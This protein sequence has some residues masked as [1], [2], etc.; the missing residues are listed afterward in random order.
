MY[1]I[2]YAFIRCTQCDLIFENELTFRNHVIDSGHETML[3]GQ[4]Y[5]SNKRIKRSAAKAAQKIIDQINI[6]LVNE[7]D[8]ETQAQGQKSDV[9]SIKKEN[10]EDEWVNTFF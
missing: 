7:E 10:L 1:N 2:Y 4:V 5:D 6:S 9:I 8:E 3:N